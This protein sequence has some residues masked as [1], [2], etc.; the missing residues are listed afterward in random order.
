M[1]YCEQETKAI[2]VKNGK[3]KE[4]VMEEQVIITIGREFGSG[5]REIAEKLSEEL[6]IT[7]YDKKLIQ[8][9][10]EKFHFD[11]NVLAYYDEKPVNSVLFPLNLAMLPYSVGDSVEERAAVAEF[12]VIREKSEIE[13]FIVVGRCAEHILKDKD[14]LS[15][16][17]SADPKDRIARICKKYDLYDHDAK[18]LI[19]RSNN[20]RRHYHDYYC[21]N[22]WG[23]AT[24][25]DLCLNSSF[26]GI[27]GCVKL[28]KESIQL[29][30]KKQ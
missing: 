11:E 28:I 1:I 2:K 16:F 18:A 9:A 26:F 5:G 12:S 27:D 21:D 24:T 8:S 15:V 13:S 22:P 17:I 29:H 10:A 6:G 14:I 30:K 20:V 25:Y 23:E 4:G 19:N 3:N 7:L